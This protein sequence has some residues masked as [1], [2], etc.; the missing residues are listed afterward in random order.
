[1]N[2]YQPLGPEI[3]YENDAD[4]L[5]KFVE[6]NN[7]DGELVYELYNFHCRGDLEQL[8]EMFEKYQGCFECLGIWAEKFHIECGNIKKIPEFFRDY[9][10]W[11][12]IARNAE[13]DG[14]IFSIKT[15]Y[16]HVHIFLI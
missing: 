10:D 7:F 16:K 13:L 2:S 9:V 1:M 4:L 14:E 8:K 3:D 12:S 15:G 6:E 11:K 5:D